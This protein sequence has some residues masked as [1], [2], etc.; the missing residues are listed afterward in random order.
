MHG[1]VAS[2]G[3]ALRPELVDGLILS[4]PALDPGL[5]LFQKLLV[6][7]LPSIVPDL[8]VGNGL[9]PE[10]ISHDAAEIAGYIQDPLVHDRISARLAGFIAEQGPVVIEQA[11]LW[12][13]PTLL[14]YAGQD[15]LVNP[16]GSRAFGK[17]A[18]LDVVTTRRFDALYH[19]IFNE[20]QVGQEQVMEVLQDWL[21]RHF[22]IY[23]SEK[24]PNLQA[25]R[26]KLEEMKEQ[27]T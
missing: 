26:A 7:V 22:G 9:N 5:N 18:P 1:L 25:L 3:V 16:A 6:S 24:R 10:Y 23:P 12:Q 11:P 20:V 13:V 21:N 17:A 27:E 14:M 19:E 8:C 2:L 4:S 15:K